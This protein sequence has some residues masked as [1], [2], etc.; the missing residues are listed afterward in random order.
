MKVI[1]LQSPTGDPFRLGYSAGDVA[2]VKK[3]VADKLITA[4]LAEDHAKFVEAQKAGADAGAEGPEGSKGKDTVS[5]TTPPK[6]PAGSG[7]AK[8]DPDKK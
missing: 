4:G 6:V 1:F 3:E 2:D 8:A 5:G 7:K